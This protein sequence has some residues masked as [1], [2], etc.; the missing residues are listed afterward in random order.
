MSDIS[1]KIPEYKGE[2]KTIR[3]DG[4]YIPSGENDNLIVSKLTIDKDAF[5]LFGYGFLVSNV[6]KINAADIDGVKADEKILL[7]E[8][9]ILQEV[10]LSISMQRKILKKPLILQKFI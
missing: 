5:G 8:N 2:Y 4:A 10:Y 6:D 1:K 9:T 3:Q 7:M